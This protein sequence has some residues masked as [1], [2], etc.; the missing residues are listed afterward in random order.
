ME[1]K[2]FG[3]LETLLTFSAIIGITIALSWA[4]NFVARR[5]IR[6][7]VHKLNADP[8]NYQFIR[9]LV[10]ALI[11]LVGVG[12]AFLI[13]PGFKTVANSLLAGA[14]IAAVVAGLAS[15]QVLSNLMSGLFLVLFK[16]FRVND[17]LKLKDG[18]TGVVED[19]TLRHTVLRDLENNRIIVPNGVISNE[20]IVNTNLS[21]NRVCRFI[22]IGISYGSDIDKAIGIIRDEVL[23]HPLHV[24]PRTPEQLEAGKEEVEVRVVALA[25]SSVN[26]RAWAWAE[27]TP[28]AF[29]LYCDLLRS[30]K[31]RFD[32][33]GIEIPF[34]QRKL[35]IDPIRVEQVE[36]PGS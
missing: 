13:L 11:Y 28:K 19:I 1:L 36:A 18:F 4:F 9:H 34:P 12:W 26:L 17:R 5:Y 21:D 32:A 16:P 2:L 3:D 6:K 14:G 10:T 27:D 23:N 25:E 29:N 31:L 33:E 20:I 24:D 30:I 22:D 15:Q 8:T 7:A 35:W